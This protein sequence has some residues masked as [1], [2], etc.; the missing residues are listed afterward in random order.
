[1]IGKGADVN[2]MDYYGTTPLHLLC[3]YYKI[4]N[5]IKEDENLKSLV[6]LFLKYGARI[7][8]KNNEGTTPNDY[9]NRRNTTISEMESTNRPTSR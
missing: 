8:A 2:A 7:D 1:M 5:A 3:S 9:L 6:S 4:D